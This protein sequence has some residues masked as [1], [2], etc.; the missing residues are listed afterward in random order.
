MEP[1]LTLVGLG[2]VGWALGFVGAVV[3]F[4]LWLYCLFDV[5]AKPTRGA[6]SKAIWAVA[7]V[8]LAPF[9]I[10]AYLLVGRRTQ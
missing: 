3:F 9:A 6:G 7:L 4:V 8:V 1:T 5:L 10:V 2:T